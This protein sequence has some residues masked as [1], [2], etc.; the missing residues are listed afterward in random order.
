MGFEKET[1]LGFNAQDFEKVNLNWSGLMRMD[2]NL[3]NM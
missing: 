3:M 2:K 1:Q